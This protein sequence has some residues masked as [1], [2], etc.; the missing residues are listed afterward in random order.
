MTFE[1]FKSLT[2]DQRI[3]HRLRV[4]NLYRSRGIKVSMYRL[5]CDV[6]LRLFV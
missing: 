1:Y 6:T 4:A 5:L 3:Q 2:P